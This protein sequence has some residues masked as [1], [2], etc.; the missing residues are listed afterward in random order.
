MVWRTD[1]RINVLLLKQFQLHLCCFCRSELKFKVTSEPSLTFFTP[2]ISFN[3]LSRGLSWILKMKYDS[4]NTRTEIFWLLSVSD[5]YTVLSQWWKNEIYYLFKSQKCQNLTFQQLPIRR[6]SLMH[7]RGGTKN[8]LYR[9][10][11]SWF[12]IKNLL[13]RNLIW[14]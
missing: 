7:L 14:P 8:F 9:A 4:K 1:V 13:K 10:S 11:N 12:S 6:L 3:G 5:R 2:L